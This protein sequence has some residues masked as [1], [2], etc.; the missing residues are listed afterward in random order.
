MEL[1][2]SQD[3]VIN[4]QPLSQKTETFYEWNENWTVG[5]MSCCDDV[6]HCKIIILN[7]SLDDL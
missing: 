7:R 4:T 3:T 1:S 6:S 2:N 5:L